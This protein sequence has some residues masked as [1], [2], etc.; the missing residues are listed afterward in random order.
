[1]PDGVD[2][3]FYHTIAILHAPVYR[4]ENASALRQDW[5]RVPLPSSQELLLNSAELGRRIAMLL[6]VEHS[7]SNVVS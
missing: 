7:V 3:L 1:M 4:N 5:P 6:N 2:H